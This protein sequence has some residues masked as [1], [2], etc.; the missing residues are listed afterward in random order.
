MVKARKDV[1]LDPIILHHLVFRRVLEAISRPGTIMEL[2]VA[3]TGED[4]LLLILESLYDNNN[5]FAVISVEESYRKMW[6]ENI[7]IRTR[8]LETSVEEADFVVF[9]DGKGKGMLSQVRRGNYLYPELGATVFFLIEGL[10]DNRGIPLKISGP[11]IKGESIIALNGIGKEDLEIL[12]ELNKEFPL[13]VES[14]FIDKGGR[15][16]TLTRAV[17]VEIGA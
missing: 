15:F 6:S 17:R 14:I 13:G 3:K 12:Q 16:L 9:P 2:P 1:L 5:T 11:G 4:C 7:K 10:S 8:S